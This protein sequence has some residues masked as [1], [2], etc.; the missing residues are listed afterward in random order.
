[1][2]IMLSYVALIATVGR[3]ASA[4]ISLKGVILI[5]PVIGIPASPLLKSKTHGRH[6]A[7]SYST[8]AQPVAM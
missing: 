7:A 6:A 4:K 5:C 1:M 2:A 8:V 3:S